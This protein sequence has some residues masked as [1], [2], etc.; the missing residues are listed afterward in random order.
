MKQSLKLFIVLL[1]IGIGIASVGNAARSGYGSLYNEPNASAPGNGL[2]VVPINTSDQPGAKAGP[3]T[4]TTFLSEAD[5][6]MQGQTFFKDYLTGGIPGGDPTLRFGDSS[7]PTQ[8]V[9]VKATGTIGT[10][11]LSPNSP[12]TNSLTFQSDTLIPQQGSWAYVCADSQGMLTIECPDVCENIAGIQPT[13]P[14]DMSLMGNNCVSE[15]TL[16]APAICQYQMIAQ[17]IDDTHAKFTLEKK[18]GSIFT[19]Y[20]HNSDI[21]I[22]IKF[23]NGGVRT[24]TAP[25]G[26]IASYNFGTV[27]NHIRILGVLPGTINGGEVCWM[28]Y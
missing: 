13:V 10:A 1:A 15:P 23:E 20:L 2:E 28:G 18:Q 14:S 26:Q 4:V 22:A 7:Q 21:S 12:A 8:P 27:T 6:V 3:L 17:R 19:T 16:N 9:S 11:S 5:A 24:I 25:Q